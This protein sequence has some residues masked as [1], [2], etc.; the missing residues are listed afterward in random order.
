[1]QGSEKKT[2]HKYI[3][4]LSLGWLTPFYDVLFEAP[5]SLLRKNMLAVIGPLDGCRLLDVGSGTGSL[6]VLV[7]QKH[8]GAEVVGLDGD[9]S[10]LEIARL[11]AKRRGMAI[12]FDL[13]MSYALPYPDGH[14]DVVLTS[15]ILHHLERQ[16]KLK[17][18]R[19]MFRVL[20]PGGQ[21]VGVDF[22]EWS[23]PVGWLFK[24]L[25]RNFEHIA[26]NLDGYLPIM[27]ASAGFKDYRELR[28]FLFGTIALFRGVKT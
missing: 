4:A 8:P 1:M 25:V 9:P 2:G 7:K 11:K 18:A 22:S 12:N 20:R 3:P 19:E 13:G 23:H 14:F 10:V 28:R 6:A 24:P 27:F 17:T 21:L 26:D 5:V 16:N 15:L